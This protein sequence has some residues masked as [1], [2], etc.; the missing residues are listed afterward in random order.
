MP[1]DHHGMEVLIAVLALV[2][3]PL[4]VEV[5]ADP[6]HTVKSWGQLLRR[7]DSTD[8]KKRLLDGGDSDDRAV[9]SLFAAEGAH[10]FPH[11]PVR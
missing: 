8:A 6:T 10:I 1:C 2:L 3:A 5:L 9:L 11:A 4:I 7:G